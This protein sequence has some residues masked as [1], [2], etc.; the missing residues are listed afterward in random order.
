M[1]PRTEESSSSSLSP[2]TLIRRKFPKMEEFMHDD[3][4]DNNDS[5][6]SLACFDFSSLVVV[7]SWD[8][9]TANAWVG[10]SFNI[11]LSFRC[12]FVEAKIHDDAKPSR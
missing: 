12:V 10:L 6:D 2:A 11:G 4:D 1:A 7:T 8:G 3:D 9:S 5:P